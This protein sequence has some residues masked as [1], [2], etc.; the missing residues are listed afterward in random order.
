MLMAH[1]L[2]ACFKKKSKQYDTSNF[3]DESVSD[4]VEVWTS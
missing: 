4:T 3:L 1:F 2:F